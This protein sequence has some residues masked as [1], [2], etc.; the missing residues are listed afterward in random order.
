MAKI[1]YNK[2]KG[3]HSV[4][5]KSVPIESVAGED[6][7]KFYT[8]VRQEIKRKDSQYAAAFSRASKI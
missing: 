5:R 3:L 1:K 7:E 2:T 4:L 8:S 6:Y